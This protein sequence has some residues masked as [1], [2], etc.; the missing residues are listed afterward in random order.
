MSTH[1]HIDRICV[2]IIVLCLI[3]TLLFMNGQA[4]GLQSAS[5]TMG[6]EQTL[7]DT[8]K[9]HTIDILIDDWD[10]FIA[11]CESETY[12]VCTVVI[13]NEAVKNV[14]IRGKGNTSLSTVKTMGSERYSFKIEFDQY[15]DGKNYHGLDKL[16]LNNLI[17]DN[18]YM[19]DYLAYRMMKEFGADAPLCS[20]AWI[21]VNGEDW[22]LYLAVE[23]VEDSF[24][25]RNYGRDTGDL[26]K[27]DSM[28]FGGGGPGNGKD[29]NMD[30]FLNRDTED[31]GTEQ[32]SGAGMPGFGGGTVPEGFYPSQFTGGEGMP[33][34]FDPSQ[35]SGGDGM[36]EGFDP[37]QFTGEADSDSGDGESRRSG[38]GGFDFGGIFGGMGSGDVKLQ[39]TDDDPDSYSNIFDNAKTDVSQADQ[40]RLIQ[41]L[42]QLNAYENLESVVDVD[43]VL[44]YFVVHRLHRPQLLPPRAR[45]PA[46]DDPLGLQPGLRHLPE[47]RRDGHRE[48]PHRHAHV[49]L[50]PGRAAHVGLDPE[51]C[52]IHGAVPPVFSGV[53]GHGGHHRHPRRGLCPDCRICAERPDGLLQL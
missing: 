12:S 27:P 5:R 47:F 38:R 6:Y 26:Y 28:S 11:T 9:V 4:L 43:E 44:R 30:D 52:G 17:Q 41:A 40:T 31:D 3:L 18:T 1:K 33:E 45:R 32:E 49:R 21:T 25:Q 19:K 42:K 7:F 16:S 10:S 29:F 39:Y 50:R 20:F 23:G 51:Q 14:A 53:P 37:S 36:P 8:S 34:G 15:E 35:F 48:R 46:L 2:V 22:G 13:D 24:L